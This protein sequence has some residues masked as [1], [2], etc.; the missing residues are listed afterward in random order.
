MELP[1]ANRG[2]SQGGVA[3]L[4]VDASRP[5]VGAVDAG[6]RP[7]AELYTVTGRVRKGQSTPAP[8][9]RSARRAA[10]STPANGEGEAAV[11]A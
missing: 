6:D 10:V 7:V 3:I 4:G 5:A 1:F 9:G 8:D 11:A 2:G